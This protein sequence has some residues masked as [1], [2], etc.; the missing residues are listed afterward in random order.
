MATERRIPAK[1]SDFNSYLGTTVTALNTGTPNGAERLG[2]TTAEHNEWIDYFN[3]W[4]ANYALYVNP[5][6]RTKTITDQ[7]NSI[8][9]AF[10]N[11]ARPLLN[12]IAASPNLTPSDRNT[13]NLPERDTTPTPRGPIY[14]APIANFK[15]LGGGKM[16]VR[17]QRDTDAT[18]ASLHPLADGVELR[19]TILKENTGNNP[20]DPERE[21]D[22]MPTPEKCTHSQLSSTALIHLTFTTDLLGKRII[23][24][25][26]WINLTNPANNSGWSEFFTGIIS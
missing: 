16:E 5:D 21:G 10:G 26:R 2:L 22:G 13:F 14:E 25:A 17:V 7:K 15:S 9:E 19:Y 3:Q 11:F 6:T 20:P 23:G 8:K 4:S 1:D 24:F 18:R 12:R